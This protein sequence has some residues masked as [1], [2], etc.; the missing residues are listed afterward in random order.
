[1]FKEKPRAVQQAPTIHSA[2][3]ASTLT[4]VSPENQPLAQELIFFTALLLFETI[5][6]ILSLL[7]PG[8]AFRRTHDM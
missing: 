3:T 7:V 8:P 2:A 5:P 4:P 1:M 6:I